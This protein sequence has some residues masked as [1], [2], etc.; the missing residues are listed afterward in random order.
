MI[1]GHRVFEPAEGIPVWDIDPYDEAVLADPNAYYAELRAKGP[2]VYIP[3]YSILASGRYE[4]TKEI[5]SD[6]ARF[7]SS[8]GVG[9]N[10]FRYG[11]PWRPPSIILEVDPPEHART[12]KVMARALSPKAIS[13]FKEDFRVKAVEIVDAL[14]E[15]RRFE[16]VVELAEAFP[17]AVFPEAL[18]M[19]DHDPRPLVDYGAMVFNSMGPDNA[20][21]RK[22]GAMIPEIVPWIMSA[23]ARSRLRPDG[24]GAIIYEAADA[25]EITQEEAGLLIRSFLSAGVDTTVTGIGNALWCLASNPAEYERLKVDPSLARPC[26]EEVLRYTSPVH[27]FGRTA[28]VDTEIAGL[29]IAEGSKIICVLGAANL[30]PEKWEAPESFRIDRRPAGHMAFGAG[31]HGCVGQNIARLELETLLTVMAAKVDRIEFDGEVVWRPNN[32]IHALDR[33]PLEFI[34]K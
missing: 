27:T 26:F 12:R 7:V 10:D 25:G 5:F 20:L 32:A 9:L 18:G 3:K 29:K 34:A 2:L 33:M 13:K 6:H 22:A 14:L 11:T 17:T 21:R 19:V 16:A 15:K 4:E 28:A 23:C 24:M 30:D 1:E 8:R 31:I